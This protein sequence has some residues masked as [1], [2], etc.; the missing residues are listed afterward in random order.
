MVAAAGHLIAT[1]GGESVGWINSTTMRSEPLI[2]P[3]A[4]SERWCY[5][6]PPFP[7]RPR[8][9][10]ATRTGP[11]IDLAGA[12]V[13]TAEDSKHHARSSPLITLSAQCLGRKSS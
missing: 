2:E 4:R 9:A 13:R 11:L 1:I 3:P 7:S 8:E 12:R 5:A 10:L 6:E